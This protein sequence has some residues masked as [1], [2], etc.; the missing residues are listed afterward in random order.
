[1]QLVGYL[2]ALLDPE[3]PPAGRVGDPQRP[4]S[5]EAPAVG[6]DLDL[7]E[8]GVH[9]ALGRQRPELRPHPT[10]R[11]PPVLG[12]VERGAPV[13]E[14]LVHDEH[15]VR[16]DHAPVRE[17][18]VVGCLGDGAVGVHPA[19]R[20]RFQWRAAHQIE[21]EVADVRAA[22]A[23]EHHVVRVPGRV[24]AQIG[25]HDQRSVGLAA[26]DLAIPHRHHQQASVRQPPEAGRLL[27]HVGLGAQVGAVLA[28]RED[29]A[30][31]E[32]GEPDPVLPPA[33]RLEELE[34]AGHRGRLYIGH[35]RPPLDVSRRACAQC[36]AR[37]FRT[38]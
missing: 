18:H 3:Q 22:R 12:Q 14:R 4:L 25:V 20:R 28:S 7:A 30:A 27:R 33:R 10:V 31:V 15:A 21:P 11:Q 26:Q 9:R 34:P 6:R 17:P 35:A 37:G 8:D 1:M 23:V 19:Q 24:A 2:A 36:A 29:L 13:A 5:V 38:L 32:V 16:G